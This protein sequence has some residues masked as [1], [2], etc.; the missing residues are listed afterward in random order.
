MAKG[1]LG[2][3]TGKEAGAR[4]P[5]IVRLPA[6]LG[7]IGLSFIGDL[8]ALAIFFV[9]SF[10]GIFSRRQLSETMWQLYY[11][12]ATSSGIVVLVGLFTGMVLGLQLFYTLVQFG[13]ETVLGSAVALSLVRELGPVLTAIMV[14]ARAGSG[15]AA[16]VGVRRISEP[17]DA[18]QTMGIDPVRYL[19]S[20]RLA[21][22]II[23]FPILTVIFDLVGL[24]GGYVSGVLLMGASGGAYL[25]RI[26][27]AVTTEDVRSGFVKALVFAVLVSMICCFEG[28]FCHMR[29]ESSGAKNVGLA[30]RASVVL[31]CTM[32][33]VSDYVVTSLLM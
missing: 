22:S 31:S 17:I 16:E 10:I 25:Y 27:S 19:I 12:S 3:W 29:T 2:I 8:G 28:F 1:E 33:L 7:R 26:Q 9:A 18:L 21:A 15:M 4:P 6:A 20:P 5:W 32:V 13:S 11:V 23:G 14:T 30:T 24:I